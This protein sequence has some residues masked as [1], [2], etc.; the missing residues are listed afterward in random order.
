MTVALRLFV[1]LLA[2]AA[3]PVTL[4][5]PP[6]PDR[7][8]QRA[9]LKQEQIIVPTWGWPAEEFAPAIAAAGYTVV[10]AP[11]GNDIAAKRAEVAAWSA[12]GLKMLVR[13][14]VPVQ[15]PFNPADV[16]RGCRKLQQLIAHYDRHAAVIGFT[17][18]WGQ[19]DEG[20]FPFGYQF[21]EHARAAFNAH[22]NT[23]DKPLPEPPAEGH[24]G[25]LR[26]VQWHAFRSQ[27]LV[28]FRRTFVA[29]AKEATD[30]LVGT[31]SEFYPVANYELNMGA[32]P[33]ADFLMYDLSFG[34]V[35][36]NQRIAL[37][38]CHGG[39]EHFPDFASWRR[40]QLPLMAKAAGEG[41]T[42]VA[43][44]F[45]MRRGHQH[46]D[47]RGV[48][49]DRVEDEYALRIAPDI[50][51]L[52]KAVD[53]HP[54]TPEVALVY[55]SF[56]ASALPHG[57]RH[58]DPYRGSSRQIEGLLH[59]MGVHM[60]ALPLDFLASADLAKYKLVI[61]PNP[62][63][64]TD[65][66]SRN[67]EHAPTVVHAG[68]YLLAHHDPA[69][70]TGDYDRGWSAR[71]TRDDVCVHYLRQPAAR[72]RRTSTHALIAS[73]AP[74]DGVTY[75]ADQMIVLS[76]QPRAADVLMTVGDRPLLIT[77]DNGRVIHITNRLFLHA[78]ASPDDT[79]ER[80]AFRLLR[81][82]LQHAGVDVRVAG[83]PEQ[84]VNVGH[85]PYGSYGITGNVA[86]NS[87]PK[88]ITLDLTNGE[89]VTIPPHGWT[90]VPE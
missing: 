2:L 29:A 67:L 9:R 63:Y 47:A 68:E 62:V 14:T 17:L 25:T 15:D 39:M 27:S 88:A 43:F 85:K 21:S 34:D 11:H 46:T 87:T 23:P 35:T 50:R 79:L 86:W 77:S 66:M 84:R 64:L 89:L 19:T 58:C 75:P 37:G 45:P 10:N 33:G 30:K 74:F 41:V 13:P 3:A 65:E 8:A 73:L 18:A 26:W 7:A 80:L 81:N 55:Q 90:L 56:A 52:L 83:S 31:W 40:H 5:A 4:A 44:Q 1:V 36:A 57:D 32:A 60:R 76:P 12:T 42:P 53:D 48:L 71:T 24:P 72:L 20:G 82:I 54:R 69:T 59:Q 51:A 38:E 16:E 28:K 78:Y 70:A 22:L 61:I 6:S 49:I